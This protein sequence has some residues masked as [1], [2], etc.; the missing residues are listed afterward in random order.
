MLCRWF[1]TVCSLMNIFS[2][3]SLFLKPCATSAT[4]SRSRWLSGERSRSRAVPPS[5]TAGR[6][7]VVGDELPD[8]GRGGVGVQP[9][10]AGVHFA[11]ALD[12]EFG[13]GL[14]QH[15][16]R[17]AEL[18][19]LHEFVLVVGRRENDHPGFVLG[20]LQPLQRGQPVQA[21]HFQI[22]QED[23]GFVL[24]QNFQHLAPVLGLR[25]DFEILFQG[26]QPAEPVA[27]DRMV[28]RHHDA[29]LGL[30]RRSQTWKVHSCRYCSQTYNI[31][32]SIVESQ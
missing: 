3:I 25:D 31:R 13:R 1:F 7:L 12:Q 26:Q 11:D 24:L 10:L 28:V 29:D 2:A 18:H 17:G 5:G 21:G 16:A 14:L 23:V 19:R 27:E 15:D 32:T 9:D 8:D 6:C 20:D 30:R 22:E 4:I